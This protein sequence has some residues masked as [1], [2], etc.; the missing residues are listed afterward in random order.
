LDEYELYASL[1]PFDESGRLALIISVIA[2][3]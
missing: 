3:R 2:E 1:E